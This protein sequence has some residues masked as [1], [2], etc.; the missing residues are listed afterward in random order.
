MKPA[1]FAALL[2]TVA[3][4]ASVMAQDLGAP[5]GED[6]PVERAATDASQ[7]QAEE[8]ISFTVTDE[9]AWQDIGIAIP[10]FA[11]DRDRATPPTRLEP[12]RWGVRWRG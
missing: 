4:P 10:A 12:A 8:G 6:G 9:S 5:I 3:F 2:V 7:A 11:T 1:L